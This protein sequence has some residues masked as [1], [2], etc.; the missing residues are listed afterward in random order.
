[1]PL[2]TSIARRPPTRP[3]QRLFPL[4]KGQPDNVTWFEAGMGMASAGAFLEVSL[5]YTHPEQR[6][7]AK[8]RGW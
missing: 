7:L 8:L 5:M 3:P 2:H 1:M 4:P 6:S